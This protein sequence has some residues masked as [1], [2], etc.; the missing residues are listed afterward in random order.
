MGRRDRTQAEK[1]PRVRRGTERY[2]LLSGV[3]FVWKSG[4]GSLSNGLTLRAAT[5]QGR[6][7]RS[8]ANASSAS[9]GLTSKR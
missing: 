3:D 8:A 7:A 1:V 9:A 4:G 2:D 5:A 6:L